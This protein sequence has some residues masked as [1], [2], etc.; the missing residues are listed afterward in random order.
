MNIRTL[1][2]IEGA[3]EARGIAVIIDVFRAFST[4]AYLLARG[5]ERVIPVG[6]E[7]LARS[8]K[9]KDPG[10]IL[11]GERRGKILPGFDLG[12]SPAQAEELD[13]AGKTVV[14]TTSAGTQGIA[15]A[16]HAD[17]ILGGSLVTARAIADYIKSSGAT[18]VS[19]VAMGLDAVSE[20]EEDTLCANY[21]QALLEGRKMDMEA[22]VE[23]L[24]VTSG[25]KFFDPAQSDV[26]PEADFHM[27]VAVDK[28]DFVLR[29]VKQ[30]DGLS[31]MEAVRPLR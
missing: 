26:F 16:I 5:A 9:E 19:L 10:V 18:E 7:S 20:T 29:L 25:A 3:R 31:Y 4:E 28:F 27:C 8:L 14:H 1:H 2:M 13:V 15:N 12:N 22:E 11:A 24:K 17:E 23:K 6:E 21:I 30:P